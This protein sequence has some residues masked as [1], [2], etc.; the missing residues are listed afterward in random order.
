MRLAYFSP[1]PPSKSGIA[2]YSAELLPALAQGAELA[3]FV[4]KPDELRV[5]RDN[6]QF[7]V[8]DATHFDELHGQQPFDLCLYHQGNNPHHEY[9]YERALATPG[10]LVLHEHCLH[11]LIAWKTLG[12]Q[13]EAG[14]WNEMFYAYGR[15]GGRVAIAREND[16]ASEYQQF[17]LP[18]NRRIVSRSL[19]VIVHNEYAASQL[20]FAPGQTLPV[21]IIPHHLSPRAYELDQL[22]KQE[23]RRAFG[24]PE[25]A[26][27]I[28]SF[29]F[30]T[31][32]KRIP[33]LLKAFK[34]LQA[35]VPNAMCLIVGE[36]HWK[37]SVAPLIKE[38][39]LQRRVRLTGYTV[40]RD[41][42]RYLKAV[43]VVVNLRYPTAGETSGTLI[44][45]LGAG[46]PVIVS[47]FGQFGDLPDDV[48]LKVTAGPEEERELAA[49]LRAL[50]CRPNLR[51]GLGEQARNWIREN[52][53]VKRCA[54][55]YLQFAERLIEQRRRSRGRQ[56]SV[57]YQLD[58]KEAET[59][60]FDH[61]EALAYVRQFFTDDPNATDYIRVH[62]RR[63]L[64]TVELVP[65]GSPQQR[66]LELSSYLHMP[67]LIRHYGGYGDLA[68]TNWWKGETREQQQT[69]RHAETGET[70]SLPMYNVNVERDRLPFPDNHFDVALCCELIEHL[71]EDPVHMLAELHRVVKWGG[72]VIVTTPNIASAFSVREA[73]AGRTPN[74]YS[75][76]NRQSVGDR[77][78]REYTPGDVQTA[79]EA[80]GFKVFKLFTEN[81]WHETEDEFL[82]WLDA[83]TDVPRDLRGDNI[84]A[85]GRKQSTQIERF[86]ENLYD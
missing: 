32:S 48:C 30:V 23:C 9:I 17:L 8:Y 13:D 81:V 59:L 62:S 21:E 49:R 57:P 3:V 66:V 64:R 73:L 15:R 46:K 58:F 50:A 55:R 28:A 2:D 29:G 53:D 38:M 24:L 25:D 47:E 1:L 11:H 35:V 43:D 44:R 34:R 40:E 67:L 65:K 12:R 5:N 63:L 60:R 45:A 16:A 20:E 18:M 31:Q 76:Y 4:D 52:N 86:P 7:A 77:H 85:V 79:L 37:W 33:T 69:V 39:G 54:A 72:L 80:A 70:L 82:R 71:Q 36:D 56:S 61:D 51:E 83:T 27:I 19:G 74:I 10:L 22:D 41:F 26:W 14:Y 68:V 78:A 6:R 75:L 84:Y 42:F